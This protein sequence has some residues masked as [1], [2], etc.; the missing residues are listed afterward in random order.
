ML[1]EPRRE[2][3]ETAR[4][5]K[6]TPLHCIVCKCSFKYYPDDESQRLTPEQGVG[7]VEKHY[8]KHEE[9]IKLYIYDVVS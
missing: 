5:R 9:D 6:R 2:A 4:K 1:Q 7:N 3:I 8:E